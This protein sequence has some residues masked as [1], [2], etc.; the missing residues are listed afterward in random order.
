[1]LLEPLQCTLADGVKLSEVTFVVVDLETTGGSPTDHAITEIG[2]VTY[3]GGERLSA[4]QSLVDPRQPIPPYVAHLTGIDDL[5]VTGAPEIHHVLPSFLEF[6]RGAIF[7]GHNASFDFG[8]LNANLLRLDYDP[9]EGPPICTARLARRVVWPDVPNVRLATLA[10]YFRTR[11]IPVHR[12]LADAEAT[13][14]VL[15]GLIEL[16]GRLGIT[17]LGDLREACTARGRPN[18]GKIRLADLLPRS[19]GVY[20]FEDR[21]GR[22]LYVGKAVDLRARVRSYFYGDERKK[23]QDLLGAVQHVRG[24]P[25]PNG[26]AEALVLEARLIARHEPPFNAHGKRWRRYAYVKIDPAEAWPRLKVV[27]TAS[28]DDGCSYLGPFSSSAGARQA[29]DA[30]EDVFRIRRCTRSMGVR[31]RF[32]PC[33]LADMGRCL[34]PCDGRTGSEGYGELV[35]TLVSALGEP[36][37]LLAKLE[38]RMDGLAAHERFEE[39][40]LARDRLRS[41]AGSLRRLRID[42]WLTAGRLILRGAAGE[43]LELIGGALARGGEPAPEPIGSPVPRERADE[44]AAIRSWIS[45]HP[46]RVELCEVPPSEPVD[47]G[48]ALARILSALRESGRTPGGRPKG[49]R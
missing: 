40:A 33:A 46:T 15:N 45:R 6:A 41:V 31:T 2:A 13:A 25:T 26:E 48:A 16:G 11:T 42:R 1:M 32:A 34:A 20:L 9:L 28:A 49:G 10:R 30:I 27:R 47:G 23:V 14:E 8:F 24:I 4:F 29:K 43:R 19:P 36:A 22:V 12:A 21:S 17:S 38:A 7:V 35:G 39:A 37:D 44:L 3:R 5:L 18:F